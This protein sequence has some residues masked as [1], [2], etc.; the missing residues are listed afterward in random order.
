M[1]IHLLEPDDAAVDGLEYSDV[2]GNGRCRQG[3]WVCICT[4]SMAWGNLGSGWIL[5]KKNKVRWNFLLN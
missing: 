1:I 5:P 2:H 3:G 4:T